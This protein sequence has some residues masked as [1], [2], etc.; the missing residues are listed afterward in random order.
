MLLISYF[1][2]KTITTLSLSC[3]GLGFWGVD[4]VLADMDGREVL[5]RDRV[6]VLQTSGLRVEEVTFNLLEH[7]LGMITNPTIAYILLLL[8]LGGLIYEFAVPGIG[9]AGFGGAIC[10]LLGIY[11]LG[12]LPVNYVGV[13]LV[14]TAFALFIADVKAGAGGLVAL[15][16]V[17]AL[18][19]GGLLLFES[20]HFAVSISVLITSAVV[21]GIFFAFAGKLVVAIHK[22]KATTGTEGLLGA[23]GDVREDLAPQ[24]LVAVQGGDVARDGR[25]RAAAARDTCSGHGR[26]RTAYPRR[27]RGVGSF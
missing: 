4:G 14:L 8:G 5:L 19:L 18:V 1:K 20:P 26:G 10:L 11:A 9:F 23:T 15:G 22:R 13:A 27:A 16:G 21:L 6:D 2:F 12:M 25:R 17:I 24:G 7:A 3:P